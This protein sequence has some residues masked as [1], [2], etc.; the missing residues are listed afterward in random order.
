MLGL[1]LIYYIGKYYADLAEEY[2]K[3]KWGYIILGIASYYVGTFII[4]II[5]VLLY[6]LVLLK[7]IDDLND[8]VLSLIAMPFGILSCIG[9]YY[10]VKN[11]FEK[12]KIVSDSN[13]QDIGSY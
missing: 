8:L 7:S 10:L 9:V 5:I 11:N 3:K 4:G 12:N 13:I 2:N 1:L 6:E